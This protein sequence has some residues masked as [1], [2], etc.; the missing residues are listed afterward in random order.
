MKT[1]FLSGHGIGAAKASFELPKGAF[2]KFLV[3]EG[4]FLDDDV[5]EW[6]ENNPRQ[7]EYDKSNVVE[8]YGR[9]YKAALCPDYYLLDGL[10]DGLR[11]GHSQFGYITVRPKSGYYFKLSKLIE[12]LTDFI[13]SPTAFVWSACRDTAKSNN[14]VKQICKS[15]RMTEGAS[16]NDLAV[17]K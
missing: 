15:W 8:Q 9:H 6:L 1:V 13:P 14:E 7:I 3:R 16:L 12:V 2:V 10:S 5:A 17:N 11:F 4:K